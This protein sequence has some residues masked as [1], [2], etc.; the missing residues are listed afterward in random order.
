MTYGSPKVSELNL[1][2][3]SES[4]DLF[5]LVLLDFGLKKRVSFL[6]MMKSL[7]HVKKLCS[8][9]LSSRK[10]QTLR[11]GPEERMLN[12]TAPPAG[13]CRNEM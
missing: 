8:I 2:K 12:Q 1:S 4:Q 13:L 7:M 6:V 11:T 9:D 3:H 10:K 5:Q